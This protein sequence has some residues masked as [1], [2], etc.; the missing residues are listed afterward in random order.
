MHPISLHQIVAP[1][2]TP[3]ELVGIAGRLS[4]PYVCLWTQTAPGG[5]RFPVVEAADAASVRQ[6]LAENGVTANAVTS[7][8]V[9]PEVSVSS[10]EPALERGGSPGA[11][12]AN[13]QIFEL[14][15]NRAI[16]GFRAS[17]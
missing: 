5:W 6:A 1:E 2:I 10:Y 9:R 8:P 15:E 14:D 12:Y 7:F 11:T 16:D 13:V 3:V 17:G 4:C